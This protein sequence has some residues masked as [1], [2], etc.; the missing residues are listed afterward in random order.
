MAAGA[1]DEKTRLSIKVRAGGWCEFCALPLR[2][3]AQV[4]HRKPRRAGGSSGDDV[5]RASNGVWV[6]RHCHQS[7]ESHRQ[8]SYE[9][10][11][12]VRS[13]FDPRVVPIRRRGVW[14]FLTDEGRVIS[15]DMPDGFT[16]R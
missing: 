5:G 4:H 9:T 12:L 8:K 14:V 16:L 6:H 11:W 3:G 15:A 13:G 10:G 1:F 7:I 2:T